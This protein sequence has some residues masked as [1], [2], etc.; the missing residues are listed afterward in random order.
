MLSSA[1]LDVGIGLALMYLLLALVCSV[2]Q[3][4]IANITSWRGR[5]LLQ[6]I[7]RMLN[8]P[9]MSGL[10]KRVY[11]E[12]RI[13]NLTLPGKLPSYISSKAFAK[14]LVDI[15]T[16]EG[17]LTSSSVD[18]PLGPFLREAQGDVEKL[19]AAL[20]EWFDNAMDRFG[21]WYKRN[22]QLV[23]LAIAAV[24]TVG[25]NANTIE[26][27]RQIWAQPALRAAISAQA[28]RFEASYETRSEVDGHDA[29]DF[30]IDGL[31]NELDQTLPIGWT[32][33]EIDLLF[34]DPSATGG[35]GD[36]RQTTALAWHQRAWNWSEHIVGWAL[37][38]F[39]LSLGAQFWFDTLG[40]ALGLRAAG[41]KP[42][43][44]PEQPSV[45]D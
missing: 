13:K 31:M 14:A 5:H 27:A 16:E 9:T 42:T 41:P 7:K 12:P 26:V 17:T 1:A 23:I 25:V 10:A 24:V 3:E 35:V 36:R 39:A 8:D 33:A 34:H 32:S 28:A 21:G 19:R 15:V 45:A 43:Q 11:A 37:T 38:V 4:L 44:N 22:V 2:V 40:K 29:G 18:G 6:S 30:N 20:E